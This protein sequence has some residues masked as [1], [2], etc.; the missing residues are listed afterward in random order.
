MTVKSLLRW[1]TLLLPLAS[2]AMLASL[3]WLAF[4]GSTGALQQ[5]ARVGAVQAR[6]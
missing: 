3:G 6:A 4:S 5:P 1:I 2:L